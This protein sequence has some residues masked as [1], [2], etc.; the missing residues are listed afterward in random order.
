MADL[1]AD[2]LQGFLEIIVIQGERHQLGRTGAVQ[3]QETGDRIRL[4]EQRQDRPI[5]EVVAQITDVDDV[6]ILAARHDEEA[7]P[8]PE[9]AKTLDGQVGGRELALDFRLC[10]R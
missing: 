5:S 4:V 2:H 6:G 9:I 3:L 10:V 1:G 8:L 7:S